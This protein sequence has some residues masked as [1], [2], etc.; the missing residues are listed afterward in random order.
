MFLFDRFFIDI[1]NIQLYDAETSAWAK[2]KSLRALYYYAL[3]TYVHD[4]AIPICLRDYHKDLIINC[5]MAGNI[6]TGQSP[7]GFKSMGFVVPHQRQ[8]KSDANRDLI[9]SGHSEIILTVAGWDGAYQTL[10]QED[11]IQVDQDIISIVKF[12]K[13][14]EI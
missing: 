1:G 13:V 4:S 5:N 10:I 11:L 8:I 14:D 12:P 6:Q 2:F 3:N 7:V 9:Q